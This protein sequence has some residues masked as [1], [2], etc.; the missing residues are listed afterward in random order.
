VPFAC[1]LACQVEARPNFLLMRCRAAA[2]TC[3]RGGSCASLLRFSW[4]YSQECTDANWTSVDPPLI[5]AVLQSASQ[6]LNHP[7][8]FWVACGTAH[9]YPK[10]V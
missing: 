3:K 6:S 10:A 1:D 4:L 2:P 5:L 9:Q 7:S 8:F